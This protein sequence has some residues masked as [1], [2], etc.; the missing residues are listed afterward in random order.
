VPPARTVRLALALAAGG[1]A[2]AALAQHLGL[3]AERS[4]LLDASRALE[5]DSEELER[6]IRRAE[7]PEVARTALARALL[8]QAV[9]IEPEDAEARALRR[10][11]FEESARLARRV[12]ARRPASWE[13]A[14]LAGA[15]T[16]LGWSLDR[17]PRL[18][19]EYRSW[20]EPLLLARRLAPGQPEPQRY[21]AAAYL[22]LWP[23]LSD[24]KRELARSLLADALQD[25]KT[26]GGLVGPWLEVSGGDLGPVPDEPWAWAGLQATLAG[27]RDWP[28]YC[29][30]WTAGRRALRMGLE[31]QVL[32][33]ERL[34]RAGKLLQARR[35]LLDA[36]A[37]APADRSFAELVERALIAAPHGP[38]RPELRRSLAG[39][40][41]WALDQ[42]L[43]GDRPLDPEALGRLRALVTGDGSGGQEELAAAAWSHLAAGDLAAAE[44]VEDRSEL[45]WSD[46]WAPYWIVKARF[47]AERDEIAPAR[48]A[49][50]LVHPESRERAA[51]WLAR[52][53]VAR[54]AVDRE[55][56][57]EARAA[58]DALE[59]TRWPAI[60]WSWKRGRVR[61]EPWIGGPADA[62]S[63]TFGEVSAVGA[64]VAL[65]WDGRVLGC[66][67]AA[68]GRRFAFPLP[69]EAG[70][71]L[72]EV[73]TLAGDRVWPESASLRARRSGAAG[74]AA[75][76]AAPPA[77]AGR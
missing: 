20:E 22:D 18:L 38:A 28:G 1:L 74:R 11:R 48:D 36:V 8:A 16:Y 35:T 10:R 40:L 37:S 56:A 13:A 70:L 69:V 19:Q 27:R 50:A 26:F 4:A 9:E 6:A 34:L 73:E 75:A 52:R 47:L 41:H 39:W 15:A 43:R 2:V 53:L 17:D 44:S 51:Y 12:L 42:A 60:E 21:L 61:L 72:L 33:G 77:A 65:R 58:L 54:A 66:V 64:A 3:S 55:A 68:S 49:L 14:T 29:R 71:H 63:M 7:D 24:A 32:A 76:T 5:V 67:P 31:D 46:A 25:R 57:A 30:A 59:A 62:L 23:A 45:L